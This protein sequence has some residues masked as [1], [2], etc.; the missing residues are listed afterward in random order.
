MSKRAQDS[1]R[2]C[3]GWCI[4]HT[5]DEKK[6]VL[7]CAVKGLGFMSQ[8]CR[9]ASSM[10]G[11]AWEREE[12]E[13]E[14]RY[15]GAIVRSMA[16]Y[17]SH[18][19]NTL[20]LFALSSHSVQHRFE[21]RI[22]VLSLLVKSAH[23]SRNAP[24][25]S[26]HRVALLRCRHSCQELLLPRRILDAALQAR[27]LLRALAGSL[28]RQSRHLFHGPP[29]DSRIF[30]RRTWAHPR[31]CGLL[32]RGIFPRPQRYPVCLVLLQLL[33]RKQRARL[34]CKL[35]AYA[36]VLGGGRVLA[37][38]QLRLWLARAGPRLDQ[39]RGGDRRAKCGDGLRRGAGQA[40]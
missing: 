14:G 35:A 16:F 2:C 18:C 23:I 7:E 13:R 1:P 11:R 40:V 5:K 27:V 15:K 17:W 4:G 3:Y 25:S 34:L 21:S 32:G 39:Q 10:G 38:S 20:L 24:P 36:I 30:C 9:G 33:L 19:F 31:P 6:R 12:R 29:E 37:P 28:G 8:S 22:S 26:C